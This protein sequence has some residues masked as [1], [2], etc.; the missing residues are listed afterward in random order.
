MAITN[1]GT[2]NSLPSAQIPAGH[3][4]ATTTEFSDWQYKR[5]LTLSVT[6]ATVDE[7]SAD[8]TMTAIFDNGSIGIDKQITDIIAADYISSRTVTTYATLRALTTN[9]SD[10]T[11][12][13]GTWLKN[14]AETY[15]CTVDLF[16]KSSA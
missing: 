7:S 9:I 11:S 10:S 5:I 16:I 6:K 1:N 13:S 12:G 8:T 15:E 2:Q 3:T 14:T 4:R